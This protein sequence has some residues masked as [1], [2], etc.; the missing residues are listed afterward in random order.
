MAGGQSYRIPGNVAGVATAYSYS[1][2]LELGALRPARIQ[3]AERG[4]ESSEQVRS[5]TRLAVLTEVRRAF[6]E[7]LR[8]RGEIAIQAEN[9]RLVEELRKRTAV[10][11]DVGEAGRLELVRAD[12]EVVSARTSANRAQLRYI[13]ALARLRAAIG[14]EVDAELN[15][16]GRLDV[17]ES[18]PPVEELH[19]E[20][21]ERHPGLAL[22]RAEVRRAEARL[23]YE[24]AQRR[25]QPSLR[26]EVDI[27]PDT[28]TYRIGITLPL[29]VRNRREGPIAEATALV[30]QARAM[31]ESRRVE[32]QAT[33]DG[34]RGRYLEASQQVAAFEHGLLGE[35]EAAL[36]V[37]EAAYR[38]GERGIL[39]VLDA[40]RVLR[41]VRLSLHNAQ[42]DRQAALIDLDEMRARELR[43]NP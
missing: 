33:M 2:P 25:P 39:E 32:L 23:A 38:L 17:T 1:Q 29:P 4:R 37:A 31:H 7:A 28:P 41:S 21:S 20:L 19:R 35:A 18:L 12:A 27:P 40:Q 34:A 26:A 3:L 43:S 42:F 13:S 22:T 11:V 15:V 16:E 14:S 10:R 9:L 24:V 6:F 5:A 36:K 30:Q 8:E